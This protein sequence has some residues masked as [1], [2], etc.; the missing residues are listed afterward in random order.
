MRPDRGGEEG[1]NEIDRIVIVG[2]GD[3]GLITALALQNTNES[4]DI[5]IIDDFSQPIPEVGKSTISYIVFFLHEI[6]DIDFTTF[7]NEVRPV[8]KGSVYFESWG[9]RGPFHIPF[10]GYTLDP[11]RPGKKRFEVAYSRHEDRNFRTP[12]EEMVEQRKA[13]F[14]DTG[15]MYTQIAY[16]LGTDRFNE[17]LR[18]QCRRA[19]IELI[20]DR[21]TDV[22]VQDNWIQSVHGEADTHA[23]DLYLD[24]S[25]FERALMSELNNE[26]ESFDFLL[27]A[28]VVAKTDIEVDEIMPATVINSGEHGWFW[29]ID[30]Y[31]WRDLG[32]VYSSAHASQ[33]EAIAEFKAE[34][35]AIEDAEIVSYSFESGMY[36]RA[37]VG[38]CIAIGNALGFVEPLQ[39]TALTLNAMLTE[40]LS[41]LIANHRRLNH[42][43][44]RDIYNMNAQDIWLNTFDF[45]SLHYLYA[46]GDTPFWDDA[47]DR[48]PNDRLQRYIDHYHN[49]GFASHEEFDRRG[50]ELNLFG[51]LLY[52]QLMRELGVK[53]EFYEDLDITV[54]K[55]VRETMKRREQQIE[56]RIDQFLSYEEVYVPGLDDPFSIVLR[57]TTQHRGPRARQAQPE[58]PG[59]TSQPRRSP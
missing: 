5:S 58:P 19:G 16:H 45:V 53:S 15:E 41:E 56:E 40:Y 55:T 11:P 17:F 23:A 31:D 44:V 54:S 48:T 20:D 57:E 43:G 34:R 22:T 6:L 52:F 27:D 14:S 13:P 47:R 49:N 10:D 59:P 37:W 2:G 18:K 1:P 50:P 29:Q 3:A 33:D 24:A 35:P 12:G 8:W 26:F 32:Y 42:P 30:T 51:A 25:G 36:D 28:A 21:I 4:I 38:N 46:D 39:S 7:N 9:S